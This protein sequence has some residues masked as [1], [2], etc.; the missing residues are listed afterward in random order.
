M[1]RPNRSKTRKPPELKEEEL[2]DAASREFA[3]KLRGIT[4]GRMFIYGWNQES[5]SSPL[6]VYIDPSDV[7]RMNNTLESIGA[8]KS[9]LVNTGS[10]FD[11][12]TI[13]GFSGS[14]YELWNG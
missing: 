12:S 1:T 14:Y 8:P 4:N 2:A 9:D 7:E 3:S 11:L 5:S 10:K 6:C 13:T